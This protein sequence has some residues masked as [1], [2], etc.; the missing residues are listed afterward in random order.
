MPLPTVGG[1]NNTWGTIL[2]AHLT[3][4]LPV[5]LSDT[6]L[7]SPAASFDISSIDQGYT[8]LRLYLLGRGTNAATGVDPRLTF[9]ND[10]ASNYDF[11]VTVYNTT[12]SAAEGVGTAFIR[13]G[14]IPAANAPSDVAGHSVLDIPFYRSGFHKTLSYTQQLKLASSTTNIFTDVG[15]G[16]WRSTS[17]INRITI[18]LSAGNFD[19]N[20]RLII[21]GIP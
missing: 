17:A 14:S 20:S 8:H 21:Y 10:S 2:N 7:G 12:A 18:A 3:A 1:D 9:N 6:T 19:T 16:L 15:T 4:N 13:L 5:E 11:Q